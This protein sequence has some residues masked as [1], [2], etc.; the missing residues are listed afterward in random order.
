MACDIFSLNRLKLY[1]VG[2]LK[3]ENV[4][5]ALRCHFK[6]ISLYHP[7]GVKTLHCKKRTKNVS[8]TKSLP[9]YN[10]LVINGK[11]AEMTKSYNFE[12]KNRNK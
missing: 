2:N 12:E 7:F 3:V 6:H 9:N 1:S 4:Q 5:K 10:T 8:F 11:N